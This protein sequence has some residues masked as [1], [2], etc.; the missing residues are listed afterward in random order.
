MVILR[1]G[2]REDS[3]CRSSLPDAP[4]KLAFVDGLRIS[5]TLAMDCPAPV[6]WL[7]T[8]SRD[9]MLAIYCSK[10]PVA[11]LSVHFSDIHLGRLLL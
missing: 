2:A 9:T 6:E 10:P 3:C 11:L 5:T 7:Q 4:A 8:M 1:P